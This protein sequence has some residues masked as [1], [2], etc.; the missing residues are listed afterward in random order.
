MFE[1]KKKS[2]IG[3]I[4]I[5]TLI[6]FLSASIC[7]ASSSYLVTNTSGQTITNIRFPS[8][9]PSFTTFSLNIS[10]NSGSPATIQSITTTHP[11]FT[12]HGLQ[13]VDVGTVISSGAQFGVEVDF[14]I[15]VG[16]Y[17][18][19]GALNIVLNSG[20]VDETVSVPLQGIPGQYWVIN[21]YNKIY[22]VGS[23]YFPD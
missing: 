14:D 5:A 13:G 7:S 1:E 11:A 18:R 9:P 17:F 21:D 12:A 8:S 15:M 23:T 22:R 20:G 19:N 3:F 4:L 10:N 6:F 2:I 16:T